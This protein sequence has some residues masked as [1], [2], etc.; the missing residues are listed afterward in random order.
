MRLIQEQNGTKTNFADEDGK[1]IIQTEQ[2]VSAI[3]EQNKKEFNAVDERA[4]WGE[5]TKVASI[6]DSVIVDLNN[7]G[8]MR[9]HA[10]LDQK[11]FL[12]FLNHPDNR[13][14][15]TRPGKL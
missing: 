14:F 7:K 6:P 2:D 10:V 11:A 1:Y 13:A 3:V 12:A 15:R 5:F 4:R 9:G 8:I